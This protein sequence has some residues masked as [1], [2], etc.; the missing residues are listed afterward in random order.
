MSSSFYETERALAQYMILHYGAPEWQLPS[1]APPELA[2]FPVRCVQEGFRWEELPPDPTA[3][4]L[5]CAVGRSCFELSR[6]CRRVLGVDRSATFIRAA[7]RLQ[8]EGSLR[9]PVPGEGEEASEQRFSLPPRVR[10]ERVVFAVGDA[11]SAGRDEPFDLLLAAN[12]LDRLADPAA[13]LDRLPSLVRPGGQ[14]LLT[15]PYSWLPE[16]TPRERWLVPGSKRVASLL[17][18]RFTLL[19]RWELPLVLREHPRKF[20]WC[21]PEATL[22]RRNWD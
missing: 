16:Y 14:L 4:E 22:W 19:R 5:G 3:L 2:D 10:P 17:E 7:L 8:A 12:L 6:R 20:Q 21:L 15:S 11:L 9:C 18:R 1:G 13:F